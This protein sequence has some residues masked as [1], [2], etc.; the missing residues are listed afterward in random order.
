MSDELTAARGRH[1]RNSVDTAYGGAGGAQRGVRHPRA[2]LSAW[3]TSAAATLA[4]V[5]LALGASAHAGLSAYDV[6]VTTAVTG[7]RDGLLTPL[8]RAFTFLGS[9]LS[10]SVLTIV[11]VAWLVWRRRAVLSGVVFAGTM[12]VSAA[13]TT[14][15][16][17][18]V[19]RA[20]PPAVDVLGAVDTSYSFPSGHSLNSMVFFGLLAAVVVAVTATLRARVAAVAGWLAATGAIGLSRIYLGYHWMTDVLAGWCTG[21]AIL[22][23]VAAIVLR[24]GIL[25][26]DW[27]R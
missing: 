2:V 16:K 1:V 10:I 19:G 17:H 11:V 12:A 13:L 4:V 14:I 15:L 23:L 5:L 26:A 9:T 22:A 27:R 8:A 18:L 7:S 21:L 25:R 24:T 3:L 6:P 20:R